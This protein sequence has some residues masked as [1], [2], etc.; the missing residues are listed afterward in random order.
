MN[1]TLL[2]ILVDF[3]LLTL[4]SMTKWDEPTETKPAS[5]ETDAQ[6]TTATVAVM[7]QGLLDTLQSSLEEERELQELA[8][9]ETNEKLEELSSAQ[10]LL[11]E[12]ESAIQ[13][14]EQSLEEKEKTAAELANDSASLQQTV[15]QTNAKLE[16][17]SVNYEEMALQA[18]QSN[19]QSLAL[20]EE[21]KIRMAEVE[22]KE[23]ALQVAEAARLKSE[24]VAKELDLK[25]K[26][27]EEEKRFLRENVDTLKE[28]ITV[29]RQEKEI[30]QEQAVKLAD[31]VTQLAEQSE[32]LQQEFRSSI[33]I[34]ANQLFNTFLEN[35][36]ETVFSSVRNI[37]G[38]LEE[39]REEAKTVVV[40]AGEKSYALVHI[41]R[42]QLGVNARAS[43]YRGLMG[44]IRSNTG[45]LVV[46]ELDF[47]E[48]DPRLG[49]IEISSEQLELLNVERY[50]TS[51]E[52]FKFNEAVLVNARGNYYGEIEFKLDART[53]GYVKMKSKIVNRMF[54][55][56]SPSKGD[57]VLSKTGELL[58]VMVDREHCV[59][60][61][62]LLVADSLGI[63]AQFDRDAL[64]DVVSSLKDRYSDL[65][66]MVR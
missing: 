58:G 34:N 32:S 7:D 25:V 35:Q 53:P 45:A 11:E 4:L 40:T 59:I 19:A 50:F 39:Q 6:L 16:T 66:R 54:G 21:L 12:R 37:G 36:V 29:V 24:Q 30:I 41:D 62:E 26:V 18:K 65:P 64:K 22:E 3:L 10:A 20:Q 23:K 46:R 13:K 44:E 61:S 38:S 28:E 56:F 57:L 15:A 8:L 43:G 27:S 60:V 14:L 9:R 48:I 49:A 42:A 2:L 17:L 47:L 63:G 52:P 1:K 51:I 31:G 55:E 33:P 5:G